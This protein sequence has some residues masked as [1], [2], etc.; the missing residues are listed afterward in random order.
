MTSYFEHDSIYS[1]IRLVITLLIAIVGN[2]GMWVIILVLPSVQFEF[3]VD[4]AS[5]SLPFTLTM[6]G[7]ALGN[8]F[9][10]KATDRYN[11]S[12]VLLFSSILLA[13]CFV[14]ASNGLLWGFF[15]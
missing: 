10:G 4:R 2:I 15:R 5:A 11:I 14:I 3:G 12:L 1:W 6:I 8:Y 9:M 13:I 7:F